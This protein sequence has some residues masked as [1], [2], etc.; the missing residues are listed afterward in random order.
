MSFGCA[1][2]GLGETFLLNSFPCV[3]RRPLEII[4]MVFLLSGFLVLQ[5]FGLAPQQ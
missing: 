5:T 1:E 2:F 4:V 3:D